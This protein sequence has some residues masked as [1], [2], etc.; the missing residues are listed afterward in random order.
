[1]LIGA[2]CRTAASRPAL[3]RRSSM[4]QR[5]GANDSCLRVMTA[6]YEDRDGDEVAS[7]RCD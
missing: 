6:G 1:M 2:G 3:A 7:D 4:P 5:Q